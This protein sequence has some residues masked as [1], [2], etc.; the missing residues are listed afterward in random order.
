MRATE[1][2]AT[3]MTRRQVLGLLGLSALGASTLLRAGAAQTGENA[4][5]KPLNILLITADDLGNHIGCYGDDTVATPNFD[6]LAAQGARFSRGYVT[7][8]SCSPSRASILT[9]LFPHQ[10]GQMGLTNHNYKV[11]PGTPNLPSLLKKSGY[12]TGILG[13]LHV[14]PA[15]EFPFDVAA[16]D[17]APTRDPD[18]V[19]KHSR[20]FFEGGAEP[21]FLMFNFVDPHR[22]FKRHIFGSP[23]NPVDEKDVQPFPFAPVDTPKVR[24]DIADYYNGVARLDECLGRLMKSLS[25]AGQDESTLVIFVSDHGAPFA[26][27]KGTCYESSVRVPFIVRAP[28]AK[29]GQ[30]CDALV[31]TI[32]IV[33]TV[34]AAASTPAPAGLP[35]RALQSLLD[36]PKSDW[37]QSLLT[38][39]TAHGRDYYFPRRAVCDARYKLIHNLAPGRPNLTVEIDGNEI[40]KA[41]RNG[42]VTSEPA[43]R[44][45]ETAANPPEFELYDLE[46]DPHE[47]NN[48]ADDPAQREQ[49]ERLEKLLL[50]WRKST[51]DATLDAQELAKMNAEHAPF[52]DKAWQRSER[53]AEK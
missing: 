45:L 43:R 1:L 19:E 48:L 6:R 25:E 14:E 11:H 40:W 21:F 37:R 33:P 44:V 10:N 12:R 46:T 27:G 50:E 41:Y 17:P 24:R 26:R 53:A 47:F 32:D 51:H 20:E 13:K 7:Q 29:A 39:Y 2:N 35:G 30:S 23:Q 31:S 42:E 9:G 18:W 38:E 34:L 8:A 49:K 5:K 28:G 36:D 16:I 22:P 3:A 4:R 52:V 15:D